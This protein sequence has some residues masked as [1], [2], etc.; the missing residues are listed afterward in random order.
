MGT[1][2]VLLSITVSVTLILPGP[3]LNN[4]I[5][6]KSGPFTLK[7][8]QNKMNE[9]WLCLRNSYLWCPTITPQGTGF[10][11][12]ELFLTTGRTF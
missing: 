12:Q 3:L 4:K 1:F 6:V 11:F 8:S 10:L 2:S 5:I 9:N 7:G